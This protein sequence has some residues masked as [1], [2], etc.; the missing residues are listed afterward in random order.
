M[1]HP[2]L[3]YRDGYDDT[4]PE[5]RAEVKRMQALLRA[6]GFPVE[7]DG[8][9][10]PGAERMVK[11]FQ[12]GHELDDDGIVGPRTWG[13]LEGTPPPDQT[14]V[15]FVTT[16]PPDA[17]GLTAELARHKYR[18]AKAAATR[19]DVP[20][21]VIAGVA[22]RESGWGLM[23][24]PKGPRGTGDFGRLGPETAHA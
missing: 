17:A 16:F 2:L 24:K 7:A 5:L 10:G 21:A 1:A 15:E 14:E 6:Q 9:F 4:S 11:E 22:S 20:L 3:R 18:V 19:Y 8:L 12:R 23:L 13:A